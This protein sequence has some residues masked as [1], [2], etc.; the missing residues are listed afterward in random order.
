MIRTFI[1][2]I[3]RGLQTVPVVHRF[4]YAIVIGAAIGAGAWL[5]REII[6]SLP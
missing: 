1:D 2:Q 6:I 5:I 3:A 4:Q